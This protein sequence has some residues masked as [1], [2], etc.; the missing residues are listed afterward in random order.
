MDGAEVIV[1]GVLRACTYTR[2]RT[3]QN[4]CNFDQGVVSCARKTPIQMTT[5]FDTFISGFFETLPADV[6]PGVQS[7]WSQYNAPVVPKPI[8]NVVVSTNTV[9]QYVFKKGANTGK[10]CTTIVKNGQWCSKHRVAEG[11]SAKCLQIDL[12][13]VESESETEIA[14]LSSDGEQEPVHDDAAADHED[15]VRAPARNSDSEG[16]GPADEDD[17]DDDLLDDDLGG[18]DEE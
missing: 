11:V 2:K 7:A 12:L 15:T 18:G 4:S 8:A 3:N 10:S 5:R 6:R 9:C 16:D 13:A 17:F 14:Y 1:V